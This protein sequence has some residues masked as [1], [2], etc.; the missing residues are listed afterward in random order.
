MHRTAR[1]WICVTTVAFL[2]GV[3]LFP[4]SANAQSPF[5]RRSSRPT[6]SPYL[7]LLNR[8]QGNRTLN[9]YNQVRPEQRFRSFEAQ[10]RRQ[11][12]SV[13]QRLD[14]LEAFPTDPNVPLGPTG[15][16]TTFMN[17][18]TYFGVGGTRRR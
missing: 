3:G 11:F 1:F 17:L 6:T 10:T 13:Q 7:N 8:N 16:S 4:N 12:G 2:I 15:H 5:G 18:G 14:T 9:Y